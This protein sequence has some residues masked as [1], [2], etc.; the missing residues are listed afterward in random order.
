MTEA[1]EG[2]FIETPLVWDSGKNYEGAAWPRRLTGI[3]G[4]VLLPPWFVAIA[5]KEGN[6]FLSL[7]TLGIAFGLLV[8]IS[9]LL[10]GLFWRHVS[11]QSML[12][13]NYPDRS[14]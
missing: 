11:V 7:Y 1:N 10:G 3:F 14:H 4:G 8:S 2:E 13:V 9:M 5:V 12:G 6:P